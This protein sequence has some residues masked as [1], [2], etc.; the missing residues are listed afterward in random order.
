MTVRMD[1]E[2]KRLRLRWL[3]AAEAVERKLAAFAQQYRAA[4]QAAA[5]MNRPAE[6]QPHHD[7]SGRR[8]DWLLAALRV[9]RALMRF[10]ELRRKAGFNPNQPRVPAGNPG[11]GQWTRVDGGGTARVRLADA[12]GALPSPVMSDAS[13]DPI[14]PGAQYAQT[15]IT[16]NPEALTGRSTIDDTTKTLAKTL[17]RVVDILPEG[18][19][20]L[21]GIAVHTAFANAVRAQQ[22]PGIGFFDV[23]TTFSLEDGARYGSKHSIRTDVVLRNEIGDIIAIY[24][25]KT[26]GRGVDPARAAELRAKTRTGPEVPIIEL[27]LRRG[28]LLQSARVKWVCRV[29]RAIGCDQI[30]RLFHGYGNACPVRSAFEFHRGMATGH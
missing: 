8:S 28:V 7:A 16:I 10:E 19:G 4:L 11:G 1:A 20:A 29:R 5:A 27:S 18:S 2:T 26:G 22:L 25:V 23:E 9:K 21:Y 24:D 30:T 3:L 6:R 17:A 12:G 13:P 14:I 15:H